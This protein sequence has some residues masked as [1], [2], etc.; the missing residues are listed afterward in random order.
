MIVREIEAPLTPNEVSEPLDLAELLKAAFDPPL[1]VYD[2][3]PVRGLVKPRY[4]HG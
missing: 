4:P 1:P 2:G 3:R